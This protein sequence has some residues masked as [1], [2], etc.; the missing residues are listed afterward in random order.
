MYAMTYRIVKQIPSKLFVAL[1]FENPEPGSDAI[2]VDK[3]IEPT[4]EGLSV[5]S[6]AL[7][8]ITNNRNY[9]VILRAYTDE[10]HTNLLV[11]HTQ[12]VQFSVPTKLFEHLKLNR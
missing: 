11:T 6:P 1:E 9:S 12:E 8:G 7:S 2:T 4:D 3:Q 10:A 5:S